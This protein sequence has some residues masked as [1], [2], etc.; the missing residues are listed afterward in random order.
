MF[1]NHHY[2]ILAGP[3]SS[4]SICQFQYNNESLLSSCKYTEESG[5]QQVI[6]I[7]SNLAEHHELIISNSSLLNKNLCV[8]KSH[9]TEY[10]ISILV[11]DELSHKDQKPLGLNSVSEVDYASKNFTTLTIFII[12]FIE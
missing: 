3:T 6:Q 5:K 1:F 12:A 8:Q 7:P 10:V 11:G 4:R 9:L 2:I